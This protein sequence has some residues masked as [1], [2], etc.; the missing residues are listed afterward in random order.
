MSFSDGF[1]IDYNCNTS[2]FG[3]Y[4]IE[5]EEFTNFDTEHHNVLFSKEPIVLR[6][7]ALN[8]EDH[9]QVQG[10]VSVGDVMQTMVDHFGTPIS[11][12]QYEEL[13]AN[14]ELR[15]WNR[16]WI[17]NMEDFKEQV[18]TYGQHR[19]DHVAYSGLHPAGKVNGVKSYKPC[20]SS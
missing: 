13:E 19:G 20:W 1:Q 3:L 16:I 10:P 7:E 9:I 5:T 8:G 18:K 12:E 6:L 17:K 15:R 2:G 14:G 11:E 4:N